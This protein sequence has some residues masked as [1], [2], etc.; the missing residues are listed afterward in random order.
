MN[1]QELDILLARAS[2]M[3]SKGS[4]VTQLK[5]DA[6]IWLIGEIRRLRHIEEAARSLYGSPTQ[7][8]RTLLGNALDG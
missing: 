6:L 5:P 3:K 8:H 7:E 2:A 4:T 1:N